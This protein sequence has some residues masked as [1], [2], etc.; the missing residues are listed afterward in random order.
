MGIDKLIHLP[1]N[2]FHHGVI[3]LSTTINFNKISY[4]TK[5][6]ETWFF[7]LNS[8]LLLSIGPW[9]VEASQLQLT[10][11]KIIMY[12]M[13]LEEKFWLCKCCIERS[14]A[15]FVDRHHFW[16]IIKPFSKG[17]SLFCFL[18]NAQTWIHVTAWSCYIHEFCHSTD[19]GPDPGCWKAG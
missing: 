11:N 3:V 18:Q 17:F 5:L 16:C 15:V 8:S 12:N 7:F 4:V 1:F 14:W 10:A 19:I 13:Q 2:E 6:T 9:L